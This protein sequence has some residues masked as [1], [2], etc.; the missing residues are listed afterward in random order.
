MKR[1]ANFTDS[2]KKGYTKRKIVKT[3]PTK[4]SYKVRASA[5]TM[6]SKNLGLSRV[7]DLVAPPFKIKQKNYFP[8]IGDFRANNN[9]S[10]MG[11]II[12]VQN[13]SSN[14]GEQVMYEFP[15]MSCFE[16][17]YL[18]NKCQDNSHLV[19]AAESSTTGN[20]PAKQS[21]KTVMM[22]NCRYV[23][24]LENCQTWDAFVEI[25]EVQPKHAIVDQVICTSFSAADM[26]Q[27]IVSPVDMSPQAMMYQDF[28]ASKS[29]QNGEFPKDTT[30]SQSRIQ[31]EAFLGYSTRGRNFYKHYK[32]LSKKTFKLGPGSKI[33]Y[34]MVIPAFKAN[35]DFSVDALE[36]TSRTITGGS[37][38]DKTY[39]IQPSMWTKSRWL[40][41]RVWS[42]PVSSA[43]APNGLGFGDARIKILASRYLSCRP[44]PGISKAEIYSRTVDG[45]DAFGTMLGMSTPAAVTDANVRTIDEAD[46][47]IVTGAFI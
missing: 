20:I 33:D 6:T 30:F 40:L 43:V 13:L 18:A 29:I 26:S 44:V 47:E 15:H 11:Q 17:G 42:G 39:A 27:T 9:Q 46:D 22:E 10:V 21:F 24:H 45:V 3:G 25:I 37:T 19:F 28:I 8:R 12:E 36:F 31:A 32:I 4:E 16:W 41:F 1:A 23:Y 5:S 35:G 38:F 14:P 7:W 34:E 2:S